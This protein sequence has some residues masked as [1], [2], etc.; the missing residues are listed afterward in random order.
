[1]IGWLVVAQGSTAI[2]AVKEQ[3]WEAGT[4]T[5]AFR[6]EGATAWKACRWVCGPPPVAAEGGAKPSRRPILMQVILP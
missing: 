3:G 5:L 2:A 4:R 1:M 6:G